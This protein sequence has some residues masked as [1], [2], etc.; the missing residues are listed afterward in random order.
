M[1]TP[2]SAEWGSAPIRE[3]YTAD[4]KSFPAWFLCL[5]LRLLNIVLWDVGIENL[6]GVDTIIKLEKWII[7][8]VNSLFILRIQPELLI[9][10]RVAEFVL[11]YKVCFIVA[12]RI[13][14]NT[15][16]IRQ[17]ITQTLDR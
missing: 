17:R 12:F 8:S 1:R 7:S 9:E 16:L 6:K 3:V 2:T 5:K 11:F 15:L 14:G 10:L 13:K 4:S